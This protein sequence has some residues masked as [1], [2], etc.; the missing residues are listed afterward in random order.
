[1]RSPTRLRTLPATRRRRASRRRL[2]RSAGPAPGL[3]PRAP[4]SSASSSRTATSSKTA[5]Q[6]PLSPQLRG[7]RLTSWYRSTTDS[8]AVPRFTASQARV[9]HGSPHEPPPHT[10]H[11][12][13]GEHRESRYCCVRTSYQRA[14][15]A[16]PIEYAARTGPRRL[17]STARGAQHLQSQHRPSPPV[18]APLR[19]KPRGERAYNADDIDTCVKASRSSHLPSKRRDARS[20]HPA[21]HH[22]M[23]SQANHSS[24]L[25]V[26]RE[27]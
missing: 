14:R 25:T 11:V 5:L 3:A 21:M 18:T 13:R 2:A 20:L 24:A 26:S 16:L 9:T 23:A 8:P 15:G 10:T 1:M 6:R 7:R 27:T 19:A 4:R 22:R 12:R 17:A